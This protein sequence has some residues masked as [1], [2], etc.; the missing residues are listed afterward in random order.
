MVDTSQ[1]QKKTFSTSEAAEHM[2]KA[3]ASLHEREREPIELAFFTGLSYKDVAKHL[4]LPEGTV[5]SR[6]R[7]GFTTSGSPLRLSG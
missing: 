3:V 6:I 1:K 7:S 5:K 2:Q 4:K